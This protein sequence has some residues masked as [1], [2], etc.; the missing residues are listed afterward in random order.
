ST[1]PHHPSA[2]K[3]HATSPAGDPRTSILQ[4]KRLELEPNL[5]RPDDHHRR[6]AHPAQAALERVRHIAQVA[7]DE[8]VD[9]PFVA[10]LRP[11][12]LVVLPGHV[13]GLVGDLDERAVAEPEDLATVA[14]DGCD[15]RSVAT[16]VRGERSERELRSDLR[17]VGERL[18]Q[19]YRAPEV[20]ERR[21]EDGNAAG[22]L[23]VEAVVEPAA[24]PL[25]VALDTRAL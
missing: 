6:D 15:E 4:E 17:F 7:L 16:D 25:E 19:P 5:H 24:D 13:V 12:A 8:L 9:V 22:A 23:A 18:R 14:P 21:R 3:S 1:I 2:P 20:V 10:G 11:T